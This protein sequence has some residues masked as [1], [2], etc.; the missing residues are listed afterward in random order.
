MLIY[1]GGNPRNRISLS[2]LTHQGG[3]L[4]VYGIPV[5]DIKK[6][7]ENLEGAIDDIEHRD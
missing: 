6:L 2:L 1:T 3:S 5:E 4:R 7:I